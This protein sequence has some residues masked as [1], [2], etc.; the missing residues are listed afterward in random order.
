MATEK[1]VDKRSKAYRDSL[2]KLPVTAQILVAKTDKEKKKIAEK[3]GMIVTETE[4]LPTIS[5]TIKELQKQIT[6]IVTRISQLESK[7]G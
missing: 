1:K 3:A 7:V 5:A 6:G 4:K 2:K